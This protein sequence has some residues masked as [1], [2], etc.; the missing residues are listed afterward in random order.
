M[1]SMPCLKNA[2]KEDSKKSVKQRFLTRLH[3]IISRSEIVGKHRKLE[4]AESL[5]E[6]KAL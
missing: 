5:P 6:F 3:K 4:E 1:V 2:A